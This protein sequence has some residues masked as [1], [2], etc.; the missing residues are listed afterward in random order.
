M[1]EAIFA[2]SDIYIWSLQDAEARKPLGYYYVEIS[3]ICMF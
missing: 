1:A 2:S 3:D